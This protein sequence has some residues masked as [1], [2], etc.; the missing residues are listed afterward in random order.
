MPFTSTYAAQ[1]PSREALAAQAGDTLLEFG[2]PW[3]GH[4]RAIQAPLA[5]ALQQHPA[6]HHVKIEDGPRR[7]LGRAFRVRL[8]PTLIV[9]RDGRELA[10]LVRPDDAEIRQAL[11]RLGE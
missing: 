8:W 5:A 9:L 7:P 11:A 1:E 10:R 4:C 2:A 6:L 3:C